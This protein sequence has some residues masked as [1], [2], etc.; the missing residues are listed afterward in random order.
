MAKKDEDKTTP[1]SDVGKGDGA[2]DTP[3]PELK[4]AKQVRVICDGKLGPLLLEKGDVTSD[5]RYVAILAQK[6][7]KKVEAV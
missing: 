4:K 5:P 6:G 2:K 7:Q 3:S 1:A